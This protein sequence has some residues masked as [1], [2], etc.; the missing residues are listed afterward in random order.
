MLRIAD[1]VGGN[2]PK[3]A[4]GTAVS[5]SSSATDA[6]SNAVCLF[7]FCSGSDSEAE[8]ISLMPFA[9]F[10]LLHHSSYHPIT[11]PHPRHTHSTPTPYPLHNKKAPTCGR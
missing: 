1:R 6:D 11:T 4:E 2:C 5:E 7:V 8:R 9:F 10:F 3:G